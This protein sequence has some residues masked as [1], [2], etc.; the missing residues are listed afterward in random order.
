M[1]LIFRPSF[2]DVFSCLK[3]KCRDSC[4]RGWQIALD[5]ETFEKYLKSS[6]P[7]FNNIEE[8]TA[9]SSGTRFIKTEKGNCVFLNSSGL[10]DIYSSEGFSF[11][12]ETCRVHPMF[13]NFLSEGYE[14]GVG[15]SCEEGL[16]L[17]MKASPEDFVRKDV[18]SADERESFIL[19]KRNETLMFLEN[20]EENMWEVFDRVFDTSLNS[21]SFYDE[22]FYG[23]PLREDSFSFSSLV[24]KR[25]FINEYVSIL[26]NLE[27]NSEKWKE[28]LNA[29]DSDR[30]HDNLSGVLNNN[31]CRSF[32]LNVLSNQIF[33]YMIKASLD[34][35][36]IEKTAF[37]LLFVYTSALFEASLLNEKESINKENLFDI[38]MA[39][40]REAEYNELNLTTLYDFI[41]GKME[42][43]K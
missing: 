29:F 15:L 16:M 24:K 14:E 22:L 12:C 42:E 11:L 26:K 21:Q 17:V 18:S 1:T 10:C 43:T 41:I 8:K 38:T 9:L 37:C 6:N 3:E 7:L 27:I 36:M 5:E 19:E 20:C 35:D 23:L 33:R 4:C 39:F 32:Y 31:E 13:R 2:L 28:R 34:D 30:A 40:S 25:S